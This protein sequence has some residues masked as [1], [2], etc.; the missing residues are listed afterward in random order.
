MLVVAGRQGGTR[1][2]E[3]RG[4]GANWEGGWVVGSVWDV[5]EEKTCSKWDTQRGAMASGRNW[6]EFHKK[7]CKEIRATKVQAAMHPPLPKT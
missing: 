5:G 4:L 6:G 2:K 1:G 7:Q 3:L